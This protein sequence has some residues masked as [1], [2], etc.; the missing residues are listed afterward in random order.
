MQT[1]LFASRVGGQVW[2]AIRED[3]ATAELRVEPV[4]A[5]GSGVGRVLRARVTRVV[6]GMQS[7][8]LDIGT[9]RDGFLHVDDLILPGE[10]APSAASG[11][12][13]RIEDLLRPGSEL[14]VQVAR[15]AMQ[16]KGARLTCNIA[17]PGRYLVYL[18][19]VAHRSV[20][21]RIDNPGERERLLGILARLPE[22]AGGFIVRT[23]GRG[24]EEPAF[25]ADAGRLVQTWADI[26]TRAG[27][28]RA[29][30]VLH[31]EL[32]P[33]LRALRDCPADGVSRLVVDDPAIY[34]R[35]HDYLRDIDPVLA[36]RIRLHPGPQPLLEAHGLGRE[37]QRALH[38]KVW[39]AS[40][41]YVVIQET[42]ALVSIDVNTGR[43]LGEGAPEDTVLR[44][45]LE[46]ATEI[47]RQ[48]RLRDLGGIIV[49]DFIDMADPLNRQQVLEELGR[50]LRR[51]RARTK[52]VGLSELGLVQ[53]TRKRTR[54][55][56][57]AG[58]TRRCP[59]CAGLGRIKTPEVVAAEALS[60]LERLLSE[61]DRPAV[62][63]RAHP[64]VL[65]AVRLAL[66]GAPGPR[67]LRLEPDPSIVPDRF[68]LVAG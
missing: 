48:L 22:A 20:S 68:D 41:G 56:L 7:A 9:G 57:A 4:G 5:G 64:D 29:P 30:E 3:G 16:T 10:D 35:A 34:R 15:D 21:R 65:D 28:A 43:Y 6:P 13:G 36:T 50:A 58:L 46:A 55:G 33:E 1:E 62:T 42:E 47:A 24:A 54:P 45:N 60:K 17:L 27:R 51:D 14:L 12:P 52:V 25:G 37:I 38:P 61:P 23:A 39:L 26:R 53:L 67:D 8:F 66:Q 18:P 63:L 11:A 31:E 2:I 44:T 49:V 32:E 40:G 59:S 19:L